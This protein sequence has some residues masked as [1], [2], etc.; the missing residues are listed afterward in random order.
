MEQELQITRRHIHWNIDD[1]GAAGGLELM[2]S[3]AGK[4]TL[5]GTLEFSEDADSVLNIHDGTLTLATDSRKDS[6]C[7]IF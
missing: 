2:K 5:A 1:T 6:F 7:R 3:R 4:Q